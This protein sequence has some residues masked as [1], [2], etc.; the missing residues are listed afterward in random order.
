MTD[1]ADDLQ[2]AGPAPGGDAVPPSSPLAERIRDRRAR[3]GVIGLG[4]VGL[5]TMAASAAAGFQVT[6]IDIDPARV[7]QVNAG[8]S[9]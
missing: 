7:A 6:G 8:H 3:V 4:Y 2:P 1:R 5:P 9:Y